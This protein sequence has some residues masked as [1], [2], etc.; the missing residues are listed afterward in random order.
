MMRSITILLALSLAFAGCGGGGGGE[1]ETAETAAADSLLHVDAEMLPDLH[2]TTAVVAR[3]PAGDRVVLLGDVH[4]NESAYAAVS[5][6][7]AARVVRVLVEPGQAVRA[8]DALV[9]LQS[10][11][12]GQARAAFAA[13]R[14]RATQ[15]QA[16]LTRARGL[17]GDR[18]ASGR[19][20]EEAEAAA[21]EADAT[22]QAA[23]GALEAYGV[24]DALDAA[25]PTFTL[26]APLA[27]TVIERDAMRGQLVEPSHVLCAIGD[28]AH[29]W[30]V[31]HAAERDAVRLRAGAEA[32]IALDAFPGEAFAGRVALVGQAVDPVSRSIPVRVTFDASMQP[33]RP[34][35]T[36]TASV[37]V[38]SG[39]DS[40]LAVPAEALQHVGDAW[41]VFVPAG[42]GR[43]VLREVRRGRDLGDE[44]EILGGVRAGDR[45][46]VS[47]AFLL[48]AE[49][50]KASGAMGEED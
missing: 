17:A 16:A 15:A 22:L 26:R 6:P 37:I 29:P 27:G 2:L 34:G 39:A 4:V 41:H 30:L 13:A 9:V 28:L 44:V 49:A 42:D 31:L 35:M 43:F 7:V 14:A 24:D 45:V 20:L 19:D 12:L 33:L 40:V 23:R 10:A 38:A 21:Q 48:K 25:G 36:A 8:G 1:A 50:E 47:G 11:E 3:R 18:I 46:V 32:R 5:A